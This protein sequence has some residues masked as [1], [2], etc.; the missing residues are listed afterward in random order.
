MSDLGYQAIVEKVYG[1]GPHGPYAVARS[2]E[3]GSIT[4]AL[5]QDVWPEEDWPEPG[6]IVMLSRVRKKRAGWR[7]KHGRFIEPS[8]EKQQQPTSKKQKEQKA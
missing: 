3:L 2:S 7:A 1:D 4:F 6:M 8:D 5:N